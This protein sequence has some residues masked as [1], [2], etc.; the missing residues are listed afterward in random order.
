MLADSNNASFRDATIQQG[1]ADGGA[2][3]GADIARLDSF[4]AIQFGGP[5]NYIDAAI[6]T[7]TNQAH[8]EP[9]I[10]D[11]GRANGAVKAP[12]LYQSVRKHGR[13]TGHTIGVITDKSVSI[14]VSY[15]SSTQA[16]KSAWFEDQIGITGAGA[17]PFSNG[18]DSGSL[19]VDAV[20]L[21][22][23]GLL[24]SGRAAGVTLAN[25]PRFRD[26]GGA[27]GRLLCEASHLPG[28]VL[29]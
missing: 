22:P 11:I 9:E 13:T 28:F 15:P 19:I 27:P 17:A 25:P 3:P 10:I 18:G 14:W 16:S 2:S 20:G 4:K 1:T 7:I 5:A 24:F 26:L 21:Q 23:I 29:S 6:A 8:V 12:E